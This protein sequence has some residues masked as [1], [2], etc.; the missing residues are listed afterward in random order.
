MRMIGRW[1]SSC[2]RVL[3]R[4]AQSLSRLSPKGDRYTTDPKA[5]QQSGA[6]SELSAQ[7]RNPPIPNQAGWGK[8]VTDKTRLQ[9]APERLASVP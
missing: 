7:P 1:G 8:G 5:P 4:E 2:G 6:H 9:L 3:D